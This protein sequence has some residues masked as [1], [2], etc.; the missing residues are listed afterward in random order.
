MEWSAVPRSVRDA[1]DLALGSAVVETVNLEGG[2]SPGPAARCDLADG[3]RVFV[4]AAGER[5]N[6]ISP[7][8]HR[9]EGAVLGA[10]PADHPSPTLIDVVDDG[11]WVALLVEWVDGSMPPAPLADDDVARALRLVDRLAETGSG[12]H[13]VGVEP[14]RRRGR[15]LFGH[16]TGLLASP[17]RGLDPWSRTHLTQLANLESDI[18]QASEGRH[19]IHGDLRTDNMIFSV[20]GPEHDIAVDWPSAAIGAPWIDL[21]ELLP[22]LHLDGGPP[23]AEIFDTR[24]VARGADAEAVDVVLATFAG[25]LTRHA[26][27]PAPPGLPTLR[28]FQAAQARIARRWLAQRVDLPPPS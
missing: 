2:F 25:F 20:D 26:L 7:A 4:K 3:R 19:L 24:R 8:M 23:P 1:V 11:D 13:P 10:L 15:S 28:A 27:L 18:E 17:P 21:L 16:W 5:L 9:I 12:L 6:P 22:A 14:F